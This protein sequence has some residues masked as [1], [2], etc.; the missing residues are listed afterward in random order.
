MRSWR[1]QEPGMQHCSD[2]SMQTVAKWAERAITRMR[3][4]S[5]LS[6]LCLVFRF[7][8][9]AAVFLAFRIFTIAGR[10]AS[11]MFTAPACPFAQPPHHRYF[12]PS[13]GSPK[14]GALMPQP[15]HL[16]GKRSAGK[17][18]LEASPQPELRCAASLNCAYVKIVCPQHAQTDSV[19]RPHAAP[20]A[21]QLQIRCREEETG[22]GVLHLAHVLA[23]GPFGCPHFLLLPRH[24]FWPLG[25]GPPR[26]P[27]AGSS[28]VSEVGL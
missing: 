18:W 2:C 21:P 23:L 4:A 10:A 28:T 9:A 1:R 12:F 8:K 11:C 14:L 5:A 22:K 24:T 17:R 27:T 3:R 15:S 20:T 19:L 16:L 25:M 6:S 26:A 13:P 7:F